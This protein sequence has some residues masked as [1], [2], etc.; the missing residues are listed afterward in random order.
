MSVTELECYARRNDWV[1]A[2]W[3]DPSGWSAFMYVPDQDVQLDVERAIAEELSNL[4]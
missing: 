2:T 3:A 4:P 1:D